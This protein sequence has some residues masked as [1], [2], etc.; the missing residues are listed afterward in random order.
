MDKT[1]EVHL[2][3]LISKHAMRYKKRLIKM[4]IMEKMGKSPAGMKD[5]VDF[6]WGRSAP[7]PDVFCNNVRIA[8]GRNVN[9]ISFIMR[10]DDT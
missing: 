5:L 8:T 3:T 2:G 6:F 7:A 1:N 9:H 4:Q 10:V